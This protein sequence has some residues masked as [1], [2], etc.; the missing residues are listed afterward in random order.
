[1]N[2]QAKN[3]SAQEFKLGSARLGFNDVTALDRKENSTAGLL[4]AEPH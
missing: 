1:M 4:W 3:C 2:L